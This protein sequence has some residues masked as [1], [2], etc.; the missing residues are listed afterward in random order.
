MADVIRATE[1][2]PTVDDRARRFVWLAVAFLAIV[3]LIAAWMVF[4]D[5]DMPTITFDGEEA[6]YDGP[7][8]FE[9]GLVDFR[10]DASEYEPGV[11][12]LIGEFKDDSMTLEDVIAEEPE[13]GAGGVPVY[14]GRFTITDLMA[15]EAEGRIVDKSIRL[16]EDTRYLISAHTSRWDT[17]RA[18][19]AAIIEVE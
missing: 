8:T 7:T 11:R 3:G 16:D 12:I 5:D 1:A 2:T 15:D 17:D 9:P 10:F 14:L 4:S 19:P 18:F 6:V 13:I